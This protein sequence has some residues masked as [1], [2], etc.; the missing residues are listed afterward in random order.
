M[1]DD[2]VLKLSRVR[3]GSNEP[4][5]SS[6][7]QQTTLQSLHQGYPIQDDQYMKT[8]SHERTR[9]K[10]HWEERSLSLSS[11]EIKEKLRSK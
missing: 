5:S 7:A 4:T 10:K 11:E 1:K 9:E 2:P 3:E 8:A 6:S